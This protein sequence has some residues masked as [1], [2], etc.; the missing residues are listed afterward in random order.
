MP[1]VEPPKTAVSGEPA[2][3]EPKPNI[4]PASKVK[5]IIRQTTGLMKIG[6]V[7]REDEA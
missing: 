5:G 4:I 3:E 2:P 7:I 6:D 1:P